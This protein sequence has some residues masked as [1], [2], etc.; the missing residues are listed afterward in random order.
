MPLL[1]YIFGYFNKNKKI[2]ILIIIANCFTFILTILLPYLNGYFF[3]MLIER[4][5]ERNIIDFGILIIILGLVSTVL[6]YSFNIYKAKIQNKLIFNMFNDLVSHIQKAY[7]KESSKYNPTY[8]HQRINTDVNKLWGFFFDKIINAIF[9]GFTIVIVIIAIRKMSIPLFLLTIIVIPIYILSYVG[10][11]KPLYEKGLLF[12]DTQS[13]FYKNMNEQL[14][15][16]KSIKLWG[17]YEENENKRKNKFKIYLKVYMDYNKLSYFYNSLE[18]SISIIFKVFALV[19][20]GFEIIHGRLTLG[21]F[22]IISAYFGMLIQSIKFFFSFGQA[23]QDANNSYTRIYELLNLRKEKFGEIK[24]DDKNISSIKIKSLTFAYDNKNIIENLNI[25]FKQGINLVLGANGIGKSTLLYIICGLLFGNEEN[26]VF[27]DNYKIAEL[28]I[29][30]LR[31]NEISIYLQNQR[32]MDET[33]EQMLFELIGDD[34]K[35]LYELIYD[36]ELEELYLTEKFNVLE[37]LN[38]NICNLSG[39]ETQRIFLL[40][41]LLKESNIL[42]LDEPTS[43][44]DIEAK[45]EF[46]KIL[47]KMKDKIIILVT[48]EDYLYEDVSHINLIYL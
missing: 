21:T 20:A 40:P 27:F 10:L 15:F 46:A 18:S 33:V 24:V 1:R 30:D 13:R 45:K 11:K 4:P 23:Y 31:K 44:L 25:N 39:G 7:Y 12:K 36:K 17:D 6:T 26:N 42:I 16:I 14:E 2:L 38:H 22:T 47:R 9:Q 35:R 48:H 29:E 37:Y 19:F 28:N 43:D 32:G 3:D 34:L 41:V 5:S 8:L